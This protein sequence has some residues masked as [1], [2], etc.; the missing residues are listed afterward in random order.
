MLKKGFKYFRWLLG[1]LF[2]LSILIVLFYKF[3]PVPLTPLMLIRYSEQKK[4][5]EK[6]VIHHEWVPLE[7][8]SVNLQRAAIASEDQCFFEH[9]GFDLEQIRK[10]REENE[11]RRKPRGASTITQQ[12]AK[13]LF[14]WPR[15]SWLRKGLETYFTFLLELFWSKERI[16][17]VYLNSIEMGKGIY[18]AQAVAREHFNT[19]ARDLTKY[20]ASLIAATLP[21]PQRF[22]SRTPS[23][24]I[25]RRS[26]EILQQMNWIAIP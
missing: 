25:L 17:E 13:N 21:N 5:G 18:G 4:Q 26:R 15:S 11:T 12:T 8:I 22:S 1:G 7:E 16:L 6:S 20:Q 9:K 10:A 19:S 23:A 14:L 2:A 3:V 24:Y